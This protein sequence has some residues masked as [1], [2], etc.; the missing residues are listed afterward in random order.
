MLFFIVSEEIVQL[1]C[2]NHRDSHPFLLSR[3]CSI[4]IRVGVEAGVPV[5]GI[6]TAALYL[7]TSAP[8]H[9]FTYTTAR[10]CICEMW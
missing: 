9:P 7:R 10:E 2:V 3:T 6:N 4:R 8:G 1:E 5:L